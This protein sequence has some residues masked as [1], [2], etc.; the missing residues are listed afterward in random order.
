MGVS[1]VLK[2]NTLVPLS[3]WPAHLLC[4][5]C[6]GRKVEIAPIVRR[7]FAVGGSRTER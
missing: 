4:L 3:A 7:L 2:M 1:G 5:P 6:L